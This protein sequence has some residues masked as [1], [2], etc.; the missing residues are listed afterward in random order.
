MPRL[1]PKYPNLRSFD[2]ALQH[3]APFKGGRAV[4]PD[5]LSDT[6]QLV[7]Y[8]HGNG[9]GLKGHGRDC[10]SVTGIAGPGG[11]TADK[12]VGLVYI[13]AI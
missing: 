4:N 7:K 3:T 2:R 6:E 9:P 13:C 8:G 1:S 10:I 5:T 11:G 12:P